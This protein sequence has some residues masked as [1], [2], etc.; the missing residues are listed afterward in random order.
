MRRK[1]KVILRIDFGHPDHVKDLTLF[2]SYAKRKCSQGHKFKIRRST[3][4]PMMYSLDFFEYSPSSG[5]LGFYIKEMR[6]YEKK[7]QGYS[8]N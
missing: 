1:I 7:I 4:N 2:T 6:Y 5:L 8:E 3:W